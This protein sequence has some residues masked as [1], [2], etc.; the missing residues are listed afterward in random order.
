M[1]LNA[2][3]IGLGVGER[4][5]AGYEAEPRCRVVALC[6]TDPDKLAEVASRNPGRRL[7]TDPDELLTDPSID[8]VSIAS[9][10][11]AHHIQIMTALAANKHVFVEKPLCL[12]QHELDDIRHGLQERPHLRLSSNLILRRSP[13]FAKLYHE[14]R[15]GA[16]GRMYY[17]EADYNYGRIHK[18][19]EGWRGKI[20]FYSVTHGGGIHMID[21][22]MWLL[23]ERPNVV[24][25]FGN[26]IA[27]EGTDFRHNDCVTAL[28][29]FPSGT[30]AK[31]SANFGCVFPHYHNLTLYGTDA[32]FQ[33]GY[34]GAR[35]FTSRDPE[36]APV[37]VTEPYPGTA[38]GDMLPSFIASILDGAAPD[39]R[40]DEVLDAMAVSLAVEESVRL[41]RTIEVRYI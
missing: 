37:E 17:A 25:A 35:L 38:K 14:L 15:H 32:T 27:T 41:E 18:I 6:D 7:T 24:T 12:F 5:I 31:I 30:I 28:L 8:V 2:A 13:R 23:D 29:K 39:V 10:D 33:H 21:L 20:P 26:A 9:Y 16:L 36:Q 22:L 34:G 4:H 1:T 40:A 19:T 3:V 11:D